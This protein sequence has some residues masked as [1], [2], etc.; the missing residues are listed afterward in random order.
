[1]VI[2]LIVASLIVFVLNIPFGYWRDNVKKFSLQWVLAVHIPVP[3]VIII[4]IF[5]HIGFAWYTYVFLVAAFFLGQ[6][7]G[8]IIHKR[9]VLTCG[10]TRSCLVMDFLNPK[11]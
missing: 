8:S 5:G 4:R 1:M 10:K 9:K 2:N 11:C 7:V 3:F 6:Y